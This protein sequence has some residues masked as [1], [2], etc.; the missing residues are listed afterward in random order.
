MLEVREEMRKKGERNRSM[1]WRLAW[2]LWGERE[3]R[4][5][6]GRLGEGRGE[7]SG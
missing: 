1:A 2:V 7:G 6:S 4:S 3:G 5:D